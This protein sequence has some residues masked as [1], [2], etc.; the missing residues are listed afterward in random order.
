MKKVY[1]KNTSKFKAQ[2][3]QFYWY[4]SIVFCF[5]SFLWLSKALLLGYYPDFNTQYYVP[6]LVF[7]GV[8]PYLGGSGL[9][10]PQVYPP[11]EFIFFLPFSIFPLRFSSD[12][13]TILSIG[14]FV[15][16]LLM[17]S[18][19]FR[20]RFFST[21]NLILM[22][23][24]F[25]MFP[26]KF[27]LGMGQVNMF[28]LLLLASCLWLLNK[29]RDIEAGLVLGISIQIKMFPLFL[30]IYFLLKLKTKII[31]GIIITFT[32]GLIMTFIFI[33]WDIISEF[34]KIF[35]SLLSSW[36]LD[37]YNQSLAGFI[38]RS[39]GTGEL[40]TILKQITTIILILMTFFVILKNKKTDFLTISL[41]FGVLINLNIIINT[42]SWQHHF[43][44]LIIPFY[45]TVFY[46]RNIKAK[47][48]YYLLLG[49]IYLLVGINFKDPGVL[50]IILQSHV[51]FG[52][53]ILLL[54]NLSLL[55]KA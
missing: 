25:V 28:I 32:T 14:S 24:G 5:L 6:Q 52:A 47:W 33:P 42:F 19:T 7:S 26:A 15:I 3:P 53:I 23:F 2:K 41:I 30:P 54:I 38:G 36:K 40:A 37:Y 34:L 4:L 50:P 44:W 21:T 18:Q 27:T 49:M 9:Y 39:F 13:Y 43:V 16:A 8:N 22:G 1:H 10:T 46:L 11:T 31:L 20:V 17:L 51:L 55:R 48:F 12:L 35:P 29:K 45:A